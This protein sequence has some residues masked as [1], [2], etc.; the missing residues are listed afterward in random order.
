M[1]F[2]NEPQTGASK[3]ANFKDGMIVT[4]IDGEKKQFTHLEGDLIDIFTEDAEY[5]GKKYRK[6][7]LTIEH[8][9]GTTMLGFP[10]GS[11][12]G[13]AFVRMC[14]NIDVDCPIKISGGTKPDKVDPTK[15]YATMF[16]QQQNKYVKWYFKEGTEANKKIPEVK[17]VTVGKGK[18]AKEVNDYSERDE[19]FET[20]ITHFGVKLGQAIGKEAK[21]RAKKAKAQ[22][23]TADEVTEPIDDLP[24]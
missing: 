16:I 14:P 22:P 21:E 24:F 19:Y 13:N 8:E 1:G 5:Q 6:V 9:D 18:G 4:K 10:L 23:R 11:G 7:V 3:Y 20:I 17:K 12:Y 15:K 2:T